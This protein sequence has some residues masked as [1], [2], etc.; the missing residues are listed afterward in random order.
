VL[1]GESTAEIAERLVVSTHTV[2]QHLKRVFEKTGVRSRRDL[3][4]RSSSRTTSRGCGTTS[5]GCWQDLA[6]LVERGR[7]PRCR[8]RSQSSLW[9]RRLAA[10]SG[11][12]PAASLREF[13]GMSAFALQDGVV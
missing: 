10:P 9:T 2:Q 11:T 12:D 3:V 13:P 7:D 5:G 8:S 6:L 4:G 1:Q